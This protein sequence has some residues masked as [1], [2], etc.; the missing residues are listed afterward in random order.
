MGIVYKARQ[1][2]LDRLVALKILSPELSTDPGF[3]E[4]FSQEA[5]TLTKLSHPHIVG[6][7]DHGQSGG[8]YY[9]L[10]EY[11]EGVNLRKAMQ[12]A[13]FTLEQAHTLIPDLCSALQFA[14]DHHI[15]HRDMK[16]ENILIDTAGRVKI[17]DFG[18]QTDPRV[19]DSFPPFQAFV[20]EIDSG[21]PLGSEQVAPIV[22]VSGDL[23]GWK[24][25]PANSLVELSRETSVPSG[26]TRLTFRFLD[27]R[28]GSPQRFY[29]AFW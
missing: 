29:R 25:L 4:R 24:E 21:Y 5:L 20:L 27:T 28:P 16:A 15:L 19:V 14:H 12:A 9:L 17:A 18:F 6:I 26:T 10:M 11:V 1:P 8:Y 23:I 2:N 22:E 13:R 7:H 3:A